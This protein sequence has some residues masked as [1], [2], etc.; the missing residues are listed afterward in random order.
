MALVQR[1]IKQCDVCGHEWIPRSAGERCGNRECRSTK[2]NAVAERLIAGAINPTIRGEGSNPSGVPPKPDMQ[3][4][5]DICAGQVTQVSAS[6][7][8]AHPYK[9]IDR[10]SIDIGICGKTWWEDG[11]Q[12]ECLMDKG[13][14]E[15]KHGMRG[16]FRSVIS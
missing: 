13:H 4:L 1:T 9:G 14:K 3:G 5:R 8:A 6:S 10:G 7:A 12:Y 2:W 11:E 16:M 15:L